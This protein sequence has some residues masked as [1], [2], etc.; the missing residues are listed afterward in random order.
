[1]T[2]WKPAGVDQV[3]ASRSES[4][5]LRESSL[6]S[7]AQSRKPGW[8]SVGG[9]RGVS[10]EPS[11]SSSPPPSV[12]GSPQ[13]VSI[14]TAEAATNA[15]AGRERLARNDLPL[16][17]GHREFRQILLRGAGE[18][19]S[20][21]GVE[22]GAVAWAFEDLWPLGVGNDV[23][24]LMRADST[25]GPEGTLRSAREDHR[26]VPHDHWDRLA[27]GDVSRIGEHR[28]FLELLRALGAAREH[29]CSSDPCSEPKELTAAKLKTH[30]S[31]PRSRRSR[32]TPSVPA[33]GRFGSDPPARRG[34]D[35]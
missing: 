22:L 15:R 16:A 29:A 24:A 2:S 34:R 30:A 1:E 28:S 23:A 33:A 20:C 26:G 35:R 11:V 6:P 25:E 5:R 4:A 19:C 9:S 14:T 31:H 17:D 3:A 10:R 32:F 27:F 8:S 7:G 13:A 12:L 18:D 21:V